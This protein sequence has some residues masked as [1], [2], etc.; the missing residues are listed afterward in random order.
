LSPPVGSID[1][2]V[3]VDPAA[4]SVNGLAGRYRSYGRW[5]RSR[6]RGCADTG[7]E[8][9]AGKSGRERDASLVEVHAPIEP[10]PDLN[11]V[12]CA[13]TSRPGGLLSG[14]LPVLLVILDF[15][16]GVLRIQ[17]GSRQTPENGQLPRRSSTPW[18]P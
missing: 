10:P 9:E 1:G 13:F 2:L 6:R 14:G 3:E 12:C 7:R 8:D 18:R 17:V 4:R 11:R 5:W 16:R 15:Q